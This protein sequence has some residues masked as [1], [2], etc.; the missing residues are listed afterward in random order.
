MGEDLSSQKSP[1]AS[2]DDNEIYFNAVRGGTKKENV[3]GLDALSKRFTSSKS[4]DSTTN[5]PLVVHKIEEMRETI[6]KLNAELMA[7]H[8][9]E[10]TLEEKVE[11]VITNQE[12]MKLI[13]QHIQVNNLM[14][15]LSNPTSDG[16]HR[17]D[18]IRDDGVDED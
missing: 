16:H 6:Q 8:A 1:V 7:K 4:V 9:K 18:H 3:Y 17:E 14:S 11:Q 15:G 13:F 12:Q 5:Q 2:I 10:R